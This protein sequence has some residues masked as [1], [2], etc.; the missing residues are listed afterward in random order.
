MQDNGKHSEPFLMWINENHTYEEML[1]TQQSS[2]YIEK[3]L[4]FCKKF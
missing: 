2:L 1:K 3:I 4:Y